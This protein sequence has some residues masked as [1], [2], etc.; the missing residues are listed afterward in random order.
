MLNP[1]ALK[2]PSLPKNHCQKN[3]SRSDVQLLITLVTHSVARY[4]AN[5][6]FVVEKYNRNRFKKTVR[7]AFS[8]KKKK[9][10]QN[11]LTKKKNPF[12]KFFAL[13][14]PSDINQI[15]FLVS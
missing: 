6:C 13:K 2:N 7:V 9:L 1:F 5:N 10:E 15:N 11:I 14:L 4:I 12:F 8:R 3:V